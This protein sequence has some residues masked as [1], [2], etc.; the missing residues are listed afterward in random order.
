[1][2]PGGLLDVQDGLI[3]HLRPL[4]AASSSLQP[5]IFDEAPCDTNPEFCQ[6]KNYRNRF[7]SPLKLMFIASMKVYDRNEEVRVTRVAY[8]LHS[9]LTPIFLSAARAVP[10]W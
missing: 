4:A 2:S 3:L 1:M 5:P 9:K 6:C 10:L 8:R 7:P